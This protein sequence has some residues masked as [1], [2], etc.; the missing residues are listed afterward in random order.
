MANYREILRL[1]SLGE[2]NRRIA[3]LCACSRNTVS[4]TLKRAEAV[5]LEIPVSED[6]TDIKLL[7]LLFPKSEFVSE[8][9]Q[10]DF[11]YVHRELM[12][13]SVTMTLLW[14]EYCDQ[15]R[16]YEDVDVRGRHLQTGRKI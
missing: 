15:C 12:K 7:E 13:P 14:Q 3:H 5:G 6:I 11:E 16:E 9:K 10:P 8:R 1:K 2:S 4:S